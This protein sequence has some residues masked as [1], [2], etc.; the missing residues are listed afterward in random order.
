MPTFSAYLC[1]CLLGQRAGLIAVP[2]SG[3]RTVRRAIQA[4]QK[5]LD[6]G[7]A[8]GLF[9]EGRSAGPGYL[10]RSTAARSFSKDATRSP[11]S[12]CT[13]TTSGESFFQLLRRPLLR[14]RLTW[15]RRNH[16]RGVRRVP[17]PTTRFSVRQALL[18][19]GV[20]ASE[21]CGPNLPPLDSIDPCGSPPD[22]SRARPPNGLHRRP[23][24]RR[25]SPNRPQARLGGPAPPGVASESSAR[26]G[27]PLP[28]EQEAQLQALLMG[29]PDWVDT[30]LQARLGFRRLRLSR[31]DA[32]IIPASQTLAFFDLLSCRA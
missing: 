7:E 21:L 28:S 22:P 5:T 6:D 24:P 1:S 25:R 9:P 26:T 18:A 11:S 17:P 2:F 13:W 8:L 19:T 29:R 32:P 4:A 10:G 31:P 12:P 14:T 3:G 23:A 27:T 16:Q 30:G 20:R 15:K